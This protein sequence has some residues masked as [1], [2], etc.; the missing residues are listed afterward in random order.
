MP[1]E[2]VLNPWL[3]DCNLKFFFLLHC[4]FDY[5]VRLDFVPYF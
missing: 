1:Q 2:I 4:L 3:D 5:H